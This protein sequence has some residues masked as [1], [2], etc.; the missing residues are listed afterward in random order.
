[1]SVRIPVA[2]AAALAVLASSLTLGAKA[3]ATPGFDAAAAA[4][5]LDRR[6]DVWWQKAKPLKSAG[7][8][9]KCLSCH[10]A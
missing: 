5:Y 6:M 7:G 9:T 2:F 8:E 1:M 10:T 4:R 3:P